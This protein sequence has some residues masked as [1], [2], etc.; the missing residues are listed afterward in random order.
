MNNNVRYTV[1]RKGTSLVLAAALATGMVP[2]IA[3]AQDANEGDARVAVRA[4]AQKEFNLEV[5]KAYTVDVTWSS[6][7]ANFLDKTV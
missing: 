2:A 6:M 5:G 4:E 7:A 1:V 3:L